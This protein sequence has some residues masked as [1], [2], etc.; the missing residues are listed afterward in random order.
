[1]PAL[2]AGLVV[3]RWAVSGSIGSGR[4]FAQVA[5][6]SA[7]LSDFVTRAVGSGVEELV[8]VGWLTPLLALAG[9]VAIRRRRG[10]AVLL[11]LAALFP[12]PPR[13]RLQPPGVRDRLAGRFP[14]C[15]RVPERFMP[16][17]CLALAALAAFA[18]DVGLSA[19]GTSRGALVSVAIGALL[20]LLALDLRVPVCGRR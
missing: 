13:A 9:L 14:G 15:Y 20:V 4:S 1:M 12:L 3:D 2:A 19:L 8:F 7:E 16:I 10:L 18:V 6:Y 11:G 5:R 17:A